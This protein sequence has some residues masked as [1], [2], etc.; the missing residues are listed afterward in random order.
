MNP[1]SDSLTTYLKSQFSSNLNQGFD[2]LWLDSNF[3]NLAGTDQIDDSQTNPFYN[4]PFIPGGLNISNASLP[5]FA[6]YKFTNGSLGYHYD[7]FGIYG[8]SL[9]AAVA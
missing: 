6:K 7:L 5:E 3:P 9:A 1:F 4:L 8:H 2:S